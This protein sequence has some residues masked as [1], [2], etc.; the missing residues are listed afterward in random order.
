MNFLLPVSD[1]VVCL[2]IEVLTLTFAADSAVTVHCILSDI[3]NE[4]YTV[5]LMWVSFT[6]TTG[7]NCLH[8]LSPWRTGWIT[9]CAFLNQGH[10]TAGSDGIPPQR[11]VFS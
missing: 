6:L 3:P 4:Q 10:D 9:W 5:M 2:R 7:Q 1:N 8:D 11:E